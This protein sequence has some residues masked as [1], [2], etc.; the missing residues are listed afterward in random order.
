MFSDVSWC[1]C[2]INCVLESKNNPKNTTEAYFLTTAM[3]RQFLLF[4]HF[5]SFLTRKNFQCALRWISSLHVDMRN[6]RKKKT[7]IDGSWL[8]SAFSRSRCSWNMLSRE[9]IMKINATI[10]IQRSCLASIKSQTLKTAHTNW[11]GIK[12]S[13]QWADT[14]QKGS[15]LALNGIVINANCRSL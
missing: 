6:L 2:D 5:I 9:V 11:A 7:K 8:A 3:R 1:W 4:Q 10:I 14:H 15:W 13:L 12:S